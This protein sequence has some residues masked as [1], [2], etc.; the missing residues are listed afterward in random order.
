MGQKKDG[1]KRPNDKILFFTFSVIL[2]AFSIPQFIH[3]LTSSLTGLKNHATF[4]GRSYLLAATVTLVGVALLGLVAALTVW[5][6]RSHPSL[7]RCPPLRSPVTGAVIPS[8]SAKLDG[9]AAE[10]DKSNNQNEENMRRYQNPLRN[11]AS[12]NSE[13]ATA[14]PAPRDPRGAELFKPP[15]L[16]ASKNTNRLCDVVKQCRKDNPLNSATGSAK[17]FPVSDADVDAVVVLV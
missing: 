2:Q 7:C 6:L 8:V 16:A 13:A 11:S 9:V 17:V 14:A 12:V 15:S 4:P 10:P 1:V 5:F 3:F